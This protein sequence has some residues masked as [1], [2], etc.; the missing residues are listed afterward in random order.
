MTTPQPLWDD[1]QL[2]KLIYDTFSQDDWVFEEALKIVIR[3]RD[4]YEHE[5]DA[6]RARVAELEAALARWQ[7]KVT[8]YGSGSL[9]IFSQLIDTANQPGEDEA[10]ADLQDDGTEQSERDEDAP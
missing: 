1:R 3:L 7:P 9:S 2:D 6:A 5:L 8:D 4:E 10:W